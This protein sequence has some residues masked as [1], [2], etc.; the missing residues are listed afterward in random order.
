MS[1]VGLA[2]LFDRAG[3]HLTEAI[4]DE[5]ANAE[6]NKPCHQ[7]LIE[8]VRQRWDEWDL[9]E[10]E[11]HDECLEFDSF[12]NGFMAPYFGCYRCED[13]IQALQAID[14]DDDNKVDWNEF[15]VYLMWAL[16]EY[17]DIKTQD[18]LIDVA[19][20]KGLIPAMRDEIIKGNC[21]L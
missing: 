15:L 7:R 6:V 19:F 18:E 13:T 2:M 1:R 16:H 21:K 5:I 12:Y 20:R 14:M 10:E 17:P 4:R 8:E 3:G 9:R 11:Q